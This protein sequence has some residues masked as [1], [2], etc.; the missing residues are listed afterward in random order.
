MRR[1]PHA[2]GQFAGSLGGEAISL[3]VAASRGLENSPAAQWPSMEIRRSDTQN[4]IAGTPDKS[5]GSDH[6]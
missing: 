3:R 5:G 6:T 2:A 4:A 1:C